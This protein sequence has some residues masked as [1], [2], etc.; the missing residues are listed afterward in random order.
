MLSPGT[1]AR[2]ASCW[3]AAAAALAALLYA[4]VPG[5]QKTSNN[6]FQ[7]AVDKNGVIRGNYYDGV[8][9]TTTPVYGSVDTVIAKF[10]ARKSTEGGNFAPEDDAL[11]PPTKKGRR[12]SAGRGSTGWKSCWW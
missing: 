6:V 5:D 2:L 7:L 9:D 12:R 10:R 4:L 8:M 11:L 1:L 3:L